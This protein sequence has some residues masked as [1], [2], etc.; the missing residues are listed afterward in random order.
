MAFLNIADASH[1]RAK[2]FHGDAAS[3][4]SHKFRVKQRCGK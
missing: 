4:L 2:Q 3:V 1:R